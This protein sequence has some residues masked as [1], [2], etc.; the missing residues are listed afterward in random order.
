MSSR[1]N[2]E[3]SKTPPAGLSVKANMLWNSAGS[4]TVL[5]C[6]WLLT[7]VVVRLS[8][9]YEAAGVLS[10]ALAVYNIFAPISVY[11]MY[12]YQVSDVKRENTTGEYLT[13]RL[14]TT[15]IAL[16]ALIAYAAITCTPSALPAIILFA[17]YRLS[18][19]IIEVLHGADQLNGRMDY[20]GKSMIAQGV[21]CFAE[22]CIVFALTQNLE[23]AIG[24]MVVVTCF[25]GLLYD[26][27]RARQ[28]GPICFG[29]SRK[30][31]HFLLLSCLPIVVAAVACNAAPSAPR[32]VLAFLASDS[33]LGI[34]TSVAAPVT[35]VQMGASYLYNPLL[36][37]ISADYAAGR[38]RKL[39]TTLA[40]IS[41]GIALIGVVCA[42]GFQLCGAWILV[43][44]F[45]PSIEPYTYLLMPAIVSTIVC[46]Y[47]WFLDNVLVALRSFRGSF[48]SNIGA[49]V[50]SL[51]LSY[52]FIS[53]WNM[54]GVSFTCIA[55][56][57]LGVLLGAIYLGKLIKE[58]EG[59]G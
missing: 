49:L 38:K 22:F 30:K 44:L 16:T 25:I 17:L 57:A 4:I 3:Q 52:P 1:Q 23:L 28:F 14:V 43:L 40:K 37:I 55:A 48:V 42:L 19:R 13:F 50:A 39:L 2:I 59:N 45:G 27:P 11:R 58:M 31:T 54:N 24:G 47:F 21:L 51:A 53:L 7:I 18:A 35:I 33:A 36:S 15:A 20:I 41:G 26:Y 5:A 32:Q 8:G 9:D 12:V 29:I 34:Y 6:Q 46:A 56:F 10:L